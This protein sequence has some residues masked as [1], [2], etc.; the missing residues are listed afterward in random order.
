M[1]ALGDLSD[2]VFN[3]LPIVTCY[4]FRYFFCVLSGNNMIQELY[5]LCPII[6]VLFFVEVLPLNLPR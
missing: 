3:V 5:H 1:D 2:D 6:R 4:P